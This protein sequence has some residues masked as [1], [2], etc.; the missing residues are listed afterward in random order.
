MCTNNSRR[1][2]PGLPVIVLLGAT[3]TGKTALALQLARRFNA[4]IINADA[5][6][7][8]RGLDIGTAKPSITE[9]AEI[10]HH[11][12]DTLEPTESY[13][14][15]QFLEHA[16]E[17]IETIAQRGKRPL[18]VGGTPQYLRALLE[19]WQTP[20]V[21]PDEALRREL[22]TVSVAELQERLRAVDA[23]SAEQIGPNQRRL[24]RAL[25]IYQATGRPAS[26]QRSKR[27]PPYS[28][29]VLGLRMERSA[30]HARIADRTAWMFLHGLL[31]EAQALIDL[32]PTLPALSS[33]GYPEAR[34]VVAGRLALD[35]AI[36]RTRFATHRYVRHQET[37]LRRF[38]DVHW[39]D[40]AAAG[41]ADKVERVVR[42]FLV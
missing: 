32:D 24:I 41:Y 5:R 3:A 14:L 23:T 13:S 4:E 20:N 36:E 1:L 22:A 7:L 27:P 35:Q 18:V 10:P 34:A 12:V 19:G 8:Y 2:T 25:E 42:D 29:L 39:F 30:L 28:F 15:A 6:Y 38:S 21:A 33:I 31:E 17:I 40:S 26:E 16:Y 37:W 9:R 11:L